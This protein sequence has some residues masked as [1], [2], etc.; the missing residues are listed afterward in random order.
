MTKYWGPMGWMTL[1]SISLN[2]PDEPTIADKEILVRFM[3][4]FTE[5]IS[6]PS[7]QSHFQG[8]YRTYTSIFPQW[9]SSK[10]QLFLFIV[11]AHN[12]VNRRLDKPLIRTVADCLATIRANTKNTSLEGYRQAYMNYLIGNWNKELSGYGRIKL[13]ASRELQKLN[14]EYWSLR[15]VDLDTLVF[16]EDDV[17]FNLQNRSGIKPASQGI[18]GFNRSTIPN[19]GF[20]IRGGRLRLGNV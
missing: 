7:C 8:L 3:D 5:T 2:Y 11:R 18:A 10:F 12:T 17:L 9:N 15:E 20:K 14:N 6:C 19:V 1:H 16:P 13:G 4:R